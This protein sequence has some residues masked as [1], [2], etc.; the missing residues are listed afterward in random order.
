[1]PVVTGIEFSQTFTPD[2]VNISPNIRPVDAE[3]MDE[4]I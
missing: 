3:M 4:M 1:M 2:K